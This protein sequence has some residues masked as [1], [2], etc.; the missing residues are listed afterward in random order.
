MSRAIL[1]DRDAWSRAF[2]SGWLARFRETGERDWSQYPRPHNHP[3]DPTPGVDLQDA[4]LIVISSAGGYD[5]ASQAPFDAA[6]DLGDYSI[7]ELP[8]F[9]RDPAALAFA[10]D[11]Y[12]GAAR[13]ADV[14]VL[15]P[16]RLLE[17][18]LDAG[19]IGDLTPTWVSFMG[20]Q[21]DVRRVIDETCARVV[22][23]ALREHAQAALLVPS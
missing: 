16:N 6:N 15:L 10:H 17:E 4:R 11:R 14:G 23:V 20:Y 3:L 12:N 21:P 1:D 5:A 8:F 19:F 18:R 13:D 7:R 9:E 22:E 2:E